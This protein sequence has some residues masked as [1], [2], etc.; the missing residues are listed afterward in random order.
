MRDRDSFGAQELFTEPCARA[1]IVRLVMDDLS[2]IP[3]LLILVAAIAT[4]VAMIWAGS[5]ES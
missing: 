3:Q 5:L 2:A 4:L 1:H